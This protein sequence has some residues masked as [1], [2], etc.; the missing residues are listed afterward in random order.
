MEKLAHLNLYL[1]E[2]AWYIPIVIRLRFRLGTSTTPARKRIKRL[3]GWIPKFDVES[4]TKKY[5]E[6]LNEIFSY[7]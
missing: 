4:G 5:K 1:T 2:W 6:H 3:L 7:R